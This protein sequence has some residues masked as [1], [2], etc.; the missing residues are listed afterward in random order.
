MAFIRYRHES[1]IPEDCRVPDQDHILRVHGVHPKVMKQH[2]DFYLEV[3]HRRS[4][5]TRRQ[6]ETVAVAVSSHNRCHY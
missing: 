2:Y 4:P 6:R 5:L 3:M 1:E